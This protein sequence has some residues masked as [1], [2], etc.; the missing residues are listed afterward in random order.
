MV[1]I[2]HW[3]LFRLGKGDDG[4]ARYFRGMV[5]PPDTESGIVDVSDISVQ[6]GEADAVDGGLDRIAL[7]PQFLFCAFAFGNIHLGTHQAGWLPM[8]VDN[9]TG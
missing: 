9:K 7:D 2:F 6:V 4:F 5:S 8:I 1:L 3:L